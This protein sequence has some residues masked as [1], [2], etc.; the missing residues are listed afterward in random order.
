MTKENNLDNGG[1][2]FPTPEHKNAFGIVGA[3]EGMS[4]RDYFATAALSE[5]V[6][7]AYYSPEARLSA[8]EPLEAERIARHAY[9]YADAMLKAKG[10]WHVTKQ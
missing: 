10:A 2:A 7:V 3:T 1:S 8:Q 6:K 4:L 9:V 5:L